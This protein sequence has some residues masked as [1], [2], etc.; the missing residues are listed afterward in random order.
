M[1]INTIILGRLLSQKCYST[2]YNFTCRIG[3]TYVTQGYS[4]LFFMSNN[5]G[6]EICGVLC[7]SIL[8]SYKK[9]LGES[10]D[11]S[12]FSLYVNIYQNLFGFSTCSGESLQEWIFAEFV[13][14]QWTV[15]E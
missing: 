2:N 6:L 10:L 4:I 5:A 8:H 1:T 9:K 14:L 12:P 7:K 13:T 11:S 15:T 3:E